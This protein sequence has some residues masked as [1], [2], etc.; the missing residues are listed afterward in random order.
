MQGD[1]GTLPTM[2]DL[3]DYVLR[4][5]VHWDG[6]AHTWVEAGER[7]WAGDPSW[8]IWGIPESELCLLPGD[9]S[10]M[11]AVEL[12]CGTGYVSAWMVRRGARVVAIDNSQRQLATAQ[13]LAAEHGVAIEFLHGNAETIPYPA[14]SFDFAI[15]EYG[16]AIWA[17]PRVWIPEAWRV[18]RPGGRL[19]FLGNHPFVMLTQDFSTDDPATRTLTHPYFGMHRIDWSVEDDE[20]T[21]FNLPISE[22]FRLFDDVGFDV[23][24]YLEL[25]A[26]GPGPEVQFYVDRDW[27]YDYPAE[28]VWVL[29]KRER[30]GAEPHTA[31]RGPGPGPTSAPGIGP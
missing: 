1:P 27:A 30:G 25:R 17:D 18:L 7:H 6:S 8:G 23:T 5:R 16:V 26:P 20:G 9:M 15:S 12:G 24:R 29:T 2:E 13:R 22:W 21:E 31:G 28:Q 4:N 3:P 11:H 10:G 14:G 19:V